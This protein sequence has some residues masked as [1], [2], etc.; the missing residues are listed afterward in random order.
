MSEHVPYTHVSSDTRIGW[1]CTDTPKKVESHSTPSGELD[2]DDGT[3]A[4]NN[5]GIVH[6]ICS[7]TYTWSKFPLLSA[8]C[9][10]FYH[11]CPVGSDTSYDNSIIILQH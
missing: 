6:E 5:R 10:N 2:W 3:Y 9:S 11:W 4:K 7:N 8:N 1:S